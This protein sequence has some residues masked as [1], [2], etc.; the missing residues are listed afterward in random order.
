MFTFLL[1]FTKCYAD[2]FKEYIN[3]PVAPKELTKK[4]LRI[5]WRE[6]LG[7]DAFTIVIAFKDAEERRAQEK[8][9]H[10][11]YENWQH[12]QTLQ[13]L[14]NR[15]ERERQER[16]EVMEGEMENFEY[17]QAMVTQLNQRLNYF[18]RA[19]ARELR[20]KRKP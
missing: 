10:L 2:T 11:E 5:E 6:A 4:E 20:E 17:T 8:M 18:L 7:W 19:F 9:R 12:E 1:M 16:R 13:G 14:E 15:L 3:A